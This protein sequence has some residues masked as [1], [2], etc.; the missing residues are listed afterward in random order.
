VYP[1]GA[2]PEYPPPPEDEYPKSDVAAAA[3][4]ALV[5]NHAS[6][7]SFPSPDAYR[8]PHT[9]RAPVK[10]V[11]AI[12]TAIPAPIISPAA[13]SV[14]LLVL[15]LVLLLLLL[16]PLAAVLVIP[17]RQRI[18]HV[19][20]VVL[21]VLVVV[22]VVIRVLLLL[23]LLVLFLLLVLAVPAVPAQRRVLH[24]R[25]ERVERLGET[26]DVFEERHGGRVLAGRPCVWVQVCGCVRARVVVGENQKKEKSMSPRCCVDVIKMN[27][28]R[29][30]RRGCDEGKMPTRS[31]TQG[32]RTGHA[33]FLLPHPLPSFQ[34]GRSGQAQAQDRTEQGADRGT[35]RPRSKPQHDDRTR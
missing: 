18:I 14:A 30:M 11:I 31:Q 8:T 29:R 35:T 7:A 32:W 15:L 17:I 10:V 20:L 12:I 27:G 4:V 5:S 6:Q 9:A 19:V 28:G 24:R 16:A 34:E 1:S 22:V 23:A 3:A 13:I 33:A 21:V 25:A 2:W 26:V